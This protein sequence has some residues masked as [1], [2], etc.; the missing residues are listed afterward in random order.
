MARHLF[1]HNGVAYEGELALFKSTHVSASGA[2]AKADLPG[3]RP[4]FMYSVTDG[5]ETRIMDDEVAVHRYMFSHPSAT[6]STVP[7]RN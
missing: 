1:L 5:T 7:L 4:G 3:L 6:V 2:Q